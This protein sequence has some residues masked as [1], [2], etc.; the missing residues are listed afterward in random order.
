MEGTCEV[1][2]MRGK[3]GGT[4]KE[5]GDTLLDDRHDFSHV[6]SGNIKYSVA[7]LP[8]CPYESLFVLP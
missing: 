1:K 3:M 4:W 8:A 7:G 2:Y 6:T 5:K